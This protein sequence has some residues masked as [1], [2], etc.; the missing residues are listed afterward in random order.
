[1]RA[2]FLLAT[3]LCLSKAIGAAPNQMNYQGF[4]TDSN[5]I[6]LDTT[7]EMAFSIYDGPDPVATGLWTQ[8]SSLVTIHDGL[9]NVLFL[10]I[11][12]TVFSSDERWLGI[13][14]GGDSEM[15]PRMPLPSVP[16]AFRVSTVDGAS[17]G[18]ISGDI[19]VT[20]KSKHWN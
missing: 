19:A 9:F 10:N 6:P 3:I 14:I 5:G 1:M 17:G 15:T 8:L 12:E 18:T 13:T 4:L 7:I 2:V 16:Y 11:D 20:G